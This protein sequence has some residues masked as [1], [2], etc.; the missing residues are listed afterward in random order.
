VGFLNGTPIMHRFGI[1]VDEG[2]LHGRAESV[3][4]E[5]CSRSS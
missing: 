5:A 1:V 4:Q 2:K 3:R